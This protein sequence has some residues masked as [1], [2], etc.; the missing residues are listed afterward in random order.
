VPIYAY[1]LAVVVGVG[2]LIFTAPQSFFIVALVYLLAGFLF[3]IFW[4]IKSWRWGLWI[5][6]PILAFL[7]LSV[8]F[9]GYLNSFLKNDLPI[10]IITVTAACIGA[11]ISAWFRK[12]HTAVQQ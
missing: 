4:P 12:R 5:A 9:S 2:C 3:G 6:G 7:G 8:L 10:L 1:I 11:F